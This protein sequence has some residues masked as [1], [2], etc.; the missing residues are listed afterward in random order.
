MALSGWREHSFTKQEL[1][2]EVNGLDEVVR[3]TLKDGVTQ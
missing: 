1:Q 2:T 3:S